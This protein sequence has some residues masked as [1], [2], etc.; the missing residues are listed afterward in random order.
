[1]SIKIKP[2]IGLASALTIVIAT[3]ISSSAVYAEGHEKTLEEGKKLAFTRAKGNC[4]ACHMIPGGES[5]GNF[6]PPLISMKM[7]YPDKAK[8]RAQIWDASAKNSETSMPLFGRYEVLSESE[9]DKVV[10]YIYSL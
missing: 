10:E 8:L 6:A 3:A 5:P 1:M 2:V 9:L 4:L 7:R